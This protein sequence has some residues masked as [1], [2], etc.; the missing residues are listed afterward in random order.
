VQDF[1][2]WVLLMRALGGKTRDRPWASV[3]EEVGMHPDSLG[4]LARQL[5][6]FSLR[7]LDSGRQA[8]VADLFHTRV[9]GQVLAGEPDKLMFIGQNAVEREPSEG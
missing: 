2:H 5:T 4:R 6:G 1:L 3:A 8:T 9:L 7:D